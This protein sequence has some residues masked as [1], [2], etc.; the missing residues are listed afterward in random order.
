MALSNIINSYL[1]AGSPGGPLAVLRAEIVIAALRDLQLLQTVVI[2]LEV[3]GVDTLPPLGA[4]S[5]P[6][7]PG[8]FRPVGPGGEGWAGV[9]VTGPADLI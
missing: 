7:A 3:P 8:T 4:S 5:S 1:G 6:A 2:R 9:L